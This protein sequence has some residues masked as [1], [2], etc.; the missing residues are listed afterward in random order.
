[1]VPGQ[2][3]WRGDG[4]PR[5]WVSSTNGAFTMHPDCSITYD[6]S[7]RRAVAAVETAQWR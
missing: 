7:D 3:P 5:V 1:M 4:Y 2:V 6:V